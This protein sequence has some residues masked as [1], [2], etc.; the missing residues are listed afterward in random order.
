MLQRPPAALPYRPVGLAK[1]SLAQATS[2][3]AWEVTRLTDHGR[4]VADE[5]LR[6]FTRPFFRIDESRN[7]CAGSGLGLAMVKA[8]VRRMG[9]GLSLS[10]A[11]SGGLCAQIRLRRA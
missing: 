1:L 5:Q 3:K 8:A 7:V 10:M 2:T 6:Q 11:E 4:S 9:G